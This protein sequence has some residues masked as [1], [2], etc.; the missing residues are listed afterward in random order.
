MVVIQD[1]DMIVS[2]LTNQLLQQTIHPQKI[3]STDFKGGDTG[4]LSTDTTTTTY[5][6]RSRPHLPPLGRG[7]A[8]CFFIAA[9]KILVAHR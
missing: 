3:S 1:E 7:K 4:S 6:P 2:A 5:T 8:D 9:G